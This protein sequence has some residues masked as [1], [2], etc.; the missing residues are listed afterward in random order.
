MDV[1]VRSYL[2]AGVAAVVGATAIGLAPAPQ[3][4]DLR[5][6]AL[7]APV[8]AEIALTGTSIPWETITSLVKAL[9]SGGS[10]G[11]AVTSLIGSVGAEFAKEALPLVTALAGDVVKYVG[12]ALADLF[13]G[14]DAPQIDLPAILATATA[15]L[16]SGNFP[17]AIAALT[18]GLSVPLNQIGKVLFTPDFQAFVIGKVG[19]V[20]GALPEIL[21]AAVQTVI[22][23]DI[24]P[25]IDALSGLL[26]GLL[27]AAST[28]H[29]LT[30]AAVAA[31]RAAAAAAV[32]AES[33]AVEEVAP[34]V[35]DEAP[36]TAPAT[37]PAAE[38]APAEAAPV[39]AAPA[40][41]P[42]STP[43]EPAEPATEAA[44][45]AEVAAPVEVVAPAEV[46]VPVEVET[47]APV[48]AAEAPAAQ[49]P[50]AEAPEAPAAPTRLS[51]TGARHS[52]AKSG[53][54]SARG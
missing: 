15:A 27:P 44:P 22:G 32:R 53:A 26:G 33:V 31:P 50:A 30:A 37:K 9:S 54:G 34:A 36:E 16:S 46:A 14:P 10:I 51:K 35:A 12:T 45:V 6:V 49:A 52:S 38:A 41:A 20:L 25:L 23:I 29:A 43:A 19:G 11:D 24:K 4:P 47:V 2:T 42:A 39:E 21:R 5:A 3:A 13:T 48:A 7:P 28:T 1:S 18:S 17:G 8:V 40:E